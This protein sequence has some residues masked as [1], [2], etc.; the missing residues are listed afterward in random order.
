MYAAAHASHPPAPGA[1]ELELE[2]YKQWVGRVAGVCARVAEGDLE[3]RLM[4]CE[5]DGDIGRMVHGLNHLLD[6]TDAFVREAKASLDHASHGRFYRRVLVRGLPGTFRQAAALINEA[7]AK[8]QAQAEELAAA[9]R[10]RHELA[11]EFEASIGAVVTNVA[12]SAGALRDAATGVLDTAGATTTQAAAVAAAAEE[13]AANVQSVASAT[14]ELNASAA[15]IR[16]QIETA[17]E[18]ARGAV[19]EVERTTAVVGGLEQASGQIGRVVKLISDVARQTNL[20]ALNATIE[21]AR[22]GEVGR[23]FAVVASEVKGL[24]RQTSTATDEIEGLVR[25]IQSAAE[26]GVGAVASVGRSV[27]RVDGISADVEAAV[28]EQRSANDEI[29]RNVQQA[30]AGTVEVSRNIALVSD[31]AR[32]T[33]DAVEGILTTATFVSQQADALGEATRLFLGAVRA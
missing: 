26:A 4:G 27:H 20:L 32:R 15:E 30:A 28:G 6:V 16:R 24:A 14:E 25:S 8:M 11:A 10:R 9:Q 33:S 23:G 17:A 13:T 31:A 21:A 19:A 3:A 29:S 22:V 1:L 7:T 18:S 12:S 2:L 5:D